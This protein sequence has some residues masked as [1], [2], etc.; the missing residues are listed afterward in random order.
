MVWYIPRG[1]FRVIWPTFISYNVPINIIHISFLTNK[2]NRQ[3][4]K[5]TI[6]VPLCLLVFLFTYFVGFLSLNFWSYAC[7]LYIWSYDHRNH[8]KYKAREFSEG[9]ENNRFSHNKFIFFWKIKVSPIKFW[10]IKVPQTLISNQAT[11]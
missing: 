6:L 10:K 2:V 1:S 8:E 7:V 11:V 4:K 5:A 9:G 3:K